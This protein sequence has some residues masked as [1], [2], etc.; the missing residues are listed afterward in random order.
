MSQETVSSLQ[1]VAR[2]EE[3]QEDDVA[4]IADTVIGSLSD[5]EVAAFND[6]TQI[7]DSQEDIF[8]LPEKIINRKDPNSLIKS[9]S[10]VETTSST[11]PADPIKVLAKSSSASS[12]SSAS[13]S[14]ACIFCL[15]E[16]KNAVFVHSKFVHLCSCYKCAVKIFNKNKR[17]PICN[18]AVKNVLQLYAH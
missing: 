8:E 5:A 18:C 6:L 11:E 3:D 14:S 15:T 13:S 1:N 7:Q 2:V 16:P 9:Y 12:D 10:C 4:S 17:C